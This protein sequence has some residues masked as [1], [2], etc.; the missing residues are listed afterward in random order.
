[1][2]DLVNL[3]I[4]VTVINYFSYFISYPMEHELASPMSV[5]GLKYTTLDAVAISVKGKLL[6]CRCKLHVLEST[7]LIRMQGILLFTYILKGISP[8]LE[9]K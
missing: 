2:K 9:G 8:R 6:T 5:I 4:V 1:M 3:R 7:G